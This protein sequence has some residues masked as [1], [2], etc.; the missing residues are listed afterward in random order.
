MREDEDVSQIRGVAKLD[1]ISFPIFHNINVKITALFK[2][3]EKEMKEM[4]PV[5]FNDF[6]EA[7]T[8]A[9]VE[10]GGQMKRIFTDKVARVVLPIM[11][12]MMLTL[13]CGEPVYAMENQVPTAYDG[14]V[15]CVLPDSAITDPAT[16]EDQDAMHYGPAYRIALSACL[17][18]VKGP[19][20]DPKNPLFKVIEEGHF[21][22]Y[23]T[24]YEKTGHFKED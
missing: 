11:C 13:L 24:Y 5:T 6:M 9:L 3:E 14:E 21:K 20:I 12:I 4:K 18:P 2:Q 15:L 23:L 17:Q 19:G 16:A 7:V 8:G 22:R 10:V 1:F